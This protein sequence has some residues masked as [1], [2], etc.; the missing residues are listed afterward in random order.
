MSKVLYRRLFCQKDKKYQTFFIMYFVVRDRVLKCSNANNLFSMA[1]NWNIPDQLQ[2][3]V[4]KRDKSCVYCGVK[5]KDNYR[6]SRS[7]EHIN[8]KAKDIERWNIVLCCRSCN[9]SKG[10]KRL[11]DWFKSSYC[12]EKN[13]NKKTVANIIKQYIKQK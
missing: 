3:D 4:R 7:W 6:E 1:N 11:L 10:T 12:L 9:S 8:N 2:E 13:I 5:F